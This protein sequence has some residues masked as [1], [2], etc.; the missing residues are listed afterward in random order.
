MI[1]GF[2]KKLKDLSKKRPVNKKKYQSM[3]EGLLVIQKRKKEVKR[4]TQKKKNSPPLNTK[5]RRHIQSHCFSQHAYEILFNMYTKIL[6]DVHF[7][8]E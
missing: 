3:V 6:D 8:K 1:A 2:Q 5:L 7:E 4:I